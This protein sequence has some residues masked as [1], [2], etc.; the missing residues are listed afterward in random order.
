[1]HE[2]A[3]LW[4]EGLKMMEHIKSFILGKGN[5]RCL[6]YKLL[7]F[8]WADQNTVLI[9]SMK[10]QVGG[11]R[12]VMEL[13]DFYQRNIIYT[14]NKPLLTAFITEVLCFV[15]G[16][17]LLKMPVTTKWDLHSRSDVIRGTHG[18]LGIFCNSVQKQSSVMAKF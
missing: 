14:C 12:T 5:T 8:L 1:M 3:N 9:F 7:Y 16:V 17:E 2:Q 10:Y 4:F 13:T 15:T 6:V 11:Y 18:N